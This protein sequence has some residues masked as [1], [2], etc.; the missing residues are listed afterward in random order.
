[1]KKITVL[2]LFAT[3]LFASVTASA[4]PG[5]IAGKIYST[6]IV[7]YIDE[8]AVPSFNIGGKTV[9][10]AEELEPYGFEVIW[11]G[12]K[13]TLNV[14]TKAMPESIPQYIPQKAAG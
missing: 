10:I 1:M 3:I 2:A 11:D 8:M 14:N 4:K 13:R 7:A 12:D 9:V 6:D 5:D